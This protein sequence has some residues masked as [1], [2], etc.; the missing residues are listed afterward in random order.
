MTKTTEHKNGDKRHGEVSDSNALIRLQC[1]P[2]TTLNEESRCKYTSLGDGRNNKT[3]IAKKG[4]QTMVLDEDDI[5][6]MRRA[7]AFFDISI[8]TM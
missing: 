1:W 5:I 3:I 6:E 7:I 4:D 2:M 8:R